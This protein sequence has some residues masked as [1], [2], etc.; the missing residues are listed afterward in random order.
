MGLFNLFGGSKDKNNIKNVVKRMPMEKGP[1]KITCPYCFIR[2]TT[3]EVLFRASHAEEGDPEYEMKIDKLLNEY[4]EG[5]DMDVLP[6]LNAIIS[7]MELPRE[8]RFEVDG[9]LLEVKD[10]YDKVSKERLCPYCHNILPNTSGRGPTKVIS[11]IGSSQAGKSVYMTSLLYTLERYTA[12]RFNASL[13]AGSSKYNEE[14]KQNQRI[15]FEYNK[16]LDPTPKQH[17]DP[18]IENL[19]FKD[20][21]RPAGTFVFYDIPG[22]GMSDQV[23]IDKHGAHIKN[24][25]GIIFLVDP[26]QMRSIRK[27]LTITNKED[28]GDFTERYQEPKD[29]VVNLIENFIMKQSGERTNIPTAV[30]VTKSDMLKNLNDEDYISENSNAF[31]NCEHKTFFN[32]NEFDNIDGEIKRF[33]SKVNSPFKGVMDT[34]FSNTAYFAV[35]ALG[36]NPRNLS[37]GD[38]V[39]TPI[40]VDEP[41]LWLLYQMGYI[42]GGRE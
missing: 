33:M 15:I 23:Y 1:F 25:D 5:L 21:S 37:M 27:K 42:D 12:E 36:G 17:I 11:V 34:Y 9:V 14:I 7:P 24:S 39:V 8:S 35:S 30:V 13:T 2:F 26:L 41:F 32:F 18:L 22:E 6:E 19:K 38:G 10:K 3:N 40:R 4:R 31:R 20:D 28:K 16:M 29:I